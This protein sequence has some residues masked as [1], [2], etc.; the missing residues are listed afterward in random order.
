MARTILIG[1]VH[2]CAAELE[3]LLELIGVGAEDELVF[4]GDLVA[5]GPD[6]KGVLGIV[7]QAKGR[8]VVG[9]HE[10]RLLE[11][12]RAR[13]QGRP[14][15]KLS[16]AHEQALAEFDERDWQ[17]LEALPPYLDLPAHAVRVVHGGV[18]PRRPIEEH[19][20]HL[21]THLRSIRSDGSP[22]S[23]RDG[24]RWAA[25]YTE[26]PHIVFGHNATDGLQL[27]HCATGLDTGCVYG[28]SLTALVLEQNQRPASV[29][30]R[31]DQLVQVPAR[32]C[33]YAPNSDRWLDDRPA[34]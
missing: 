20:V 17:M 3:S 33:Y 2:G 7:R 27:Y 26:E 6:N 24:T 16:R 25:L 8:S 30:A 28:G 22:S 15:P 18:V 34:P 21:L 5:R 4:V 1:D 9:N 13:Q 31:P 11:A 32:R 14:G 29:S 12:R 19:D 23:D 10:L